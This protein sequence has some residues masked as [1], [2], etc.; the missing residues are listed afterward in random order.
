[1]LAGAESRRGKPRSPHTV[2][3]YMAVVI[4]SLNWARLQGWLESVP[5]IKKI[6]TSRLRGMKGRPITSAEF[7]RM[8]D[9]TEAVVGPE[10]APSW[11][12]LLRGLW[13]SALRLEELLCV[14]W[15]V[16]GTIRPMQ[17]ESRRPVLLIPAE[18]QKNDT[19]EAI[20]L[21][22]WFE[23]VLTE[24]PPAERTGW[25]FNP[26][27]LQSKFKWGKRVGRLKPQRVGRVIGEIGERAK[28]I[29]APSNPKTG[30]PIK[31]ASS[32]DLRRSCADRLLGAGVPPM[33]IA[34]VMRPGRRPYGTTRRVTSRPTQPSCG[35]ALAN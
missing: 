29:V 1:L 5:P 11:Q 2:K 21:L 30:R 22:P 20:P 18:M 33:T 27:T 34:T 6:K 7:G 10:A 32:H 16:D 17:R 3:G 35:T 13:A 4:A 14:S 19:E 23:A 25:A 8:L 9:A 31:Y 28:V 24:T 26:L 12:Y 15:D